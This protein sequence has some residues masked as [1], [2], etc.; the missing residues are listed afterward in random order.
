MI[1]NLPAS[2]SRDEVFKIVESFLTQNGFLVATKDKSR[3][4]GGF[5]VIDESQSKKFVEFFFSEIKEAH[6]SLEHKI[7]PKILIV[8]KEKRLSWQ[9]HKRRSEIWKVISGEVGV[10]ASDTDREGDL[11]IK[12]L[13]D[14]VILAC[15][16][17][18][19]LIGLDSWGIVAEIWQHSIPE[20]PSDEEDII[21]VQDDF[22]R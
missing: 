3:P 9:Y 22:G 4:W 5:F 18:H 11:K 14:T 15:G 13:N 16:E 7:S 17:R 21:R 10:V 20:H 1:K 19:R 2:T 6:K 8:E 12:K